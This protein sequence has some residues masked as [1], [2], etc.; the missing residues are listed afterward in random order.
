[1]KKKLLLVLFLQSF[2]FGKEIIIKKEIKETNT[3]V[4]EKKESIKIWL[5]NKINSFTP[6]FLNIS[7]KES[8]LKFKLS[9]DTKYKKLKTNLDAK[10]ILP[11]FEKTTSKVEISDKKLVSKTIPTPT[12]KNYF[13]L[14]SDYFIK[15]FEFAETI[16]FYFIHND[17]KEITSFAINRIIDIDNLKFKITKTFL[18]TK[19]DNLFYTFGLY[20]YTTNDKFIRT[21]GFE[22][23]GERKKLPF[24]YQYK[25]FLDYRQI[26]FNKKFIYFDIT[27]YLY[28]NKENHYIIKPAINISFNIKF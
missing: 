15:S 18:S 24:I 25:L 21:Y 17:F 12:I 20:Y 27:P 13:H 7:P 3:S 23:S 6:D 10:L 11:S 8:A 5:F 9:Y 19:K 22:L 26:I 4:V 2:L 14:K 16:Y 28:A 1:M